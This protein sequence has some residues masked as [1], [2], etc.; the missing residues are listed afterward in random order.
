MAGEMVFIILEN[1]DQ[2]TSTRFWVG[3]IMTSKYKLNFQSYSEAVKILDYTN[4]PSNQN[5]ETIP[6]KSRVWPTKSDV[7]LMGRNDSQILLRPREVHLSAGIF[8]KG[9]YE[10][11]EEHPS[12]IQLKQVDL[13]PSSS[14]TDIQRFSH[15]QINAVSTNINLVSPR[16]K[17]RDV[18]LKKFENNPDL[19]S[20][21]ELAERLHPAVFGDELV[22][23]IDLIIKYLL[24]HIHTPQSPPVPDPYSLALGEYTVQGKLQ[25]ICSMHVRLN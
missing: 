14:P 3:P 8:K 15:S 6:S 24:N 23:L 21:G 19:E 16:G 7:G 9:T 20:L 11:N 13:N 10:A 5:V 2:N 22:K 12:Y 1:P 17:F 4:H 25:D 18:S